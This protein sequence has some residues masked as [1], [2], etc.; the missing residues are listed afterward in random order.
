MENTLEQQRLYK[1]DLFRSFALFCIVLCHT[2]IATEDHLILEKINWFIGK[3]GVPIFIIISGYLGLPIKEGISLKSYLIKKVKRILLPF[4]VW[5]LI[6][7]LI[8]IE[9][10]Y[11][12]LPGEILNYS[13][14]HLWFIYA[15]LGLYIISPVISPFLQMASRDELKFYLILWGITGFFPLFMGYHHWLYYND[16][17]WMYILYYSYGYIGWYILG[18]YFK[19]Y[20]SS[21]LL[22]Y[23]ISIPFIL[24]FALIL[25]CGFFVFDLTTSTLCDYKAW[26]IMLYTIAVYGFIGKIEIKNA[27]VKRILKNISIYS[28]GIY[29]IHMV[30]AIYL[31][32]YLPRIEYIPVVFSNILYTSLNIFCSYLVVY[33]LSKLKYLRLLFGLN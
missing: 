25:Y 27:Q 19:R 24:L 23:K 7:M 10:G 30:F 11:T 16:H 15:I 12:I 17:N 20:P 13:G 32:P 28:F 31:Y 14:A 9:R 3:C 5:A 4:I 21:N 6:Y 29:L 1:L 2:R 33:Y 22:T 18:Y 8:D 26:P